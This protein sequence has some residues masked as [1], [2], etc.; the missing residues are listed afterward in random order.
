MP[1]N[2]RMALGMLAA[3]L[4]DG[5]GKPTKARGSFVKS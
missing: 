5:G 4:V 3:R 1:F 2:N